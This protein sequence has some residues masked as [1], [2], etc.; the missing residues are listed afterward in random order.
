[1]RLEVAGFP[2]SPGRPC[3]LTLGPWPSSEGS[4]GWHRLE[5][6]CNVA[7]ATALTFSALKAR[8][9]PGRLESRIRPVPVSSAETLTPEQWTSLTTPTISLPPTLRSMG[10]QSSTGAPTGLAPPNSR[11]A[12][13]SLTMQMGDELT[14][15]LLP[16]PL[17]RPS[18]AKISSLGV[19]AGASQAGNRGPA[20]GEFPSR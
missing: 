10:C 18:A 14:S 3:D 13:D 2:N 17:I 20:A 7:P 11:R 12:R 1:M 5:L 6:V 15:A 19:T 8:L 9:C 4:N 16:P